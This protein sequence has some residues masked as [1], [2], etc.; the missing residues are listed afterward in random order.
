MSEALEILISV[1]CERWRGA[2]ENV[3]D[4]CRRAVL[5]AYTADPPD[6]DAAEVSLM[7][8]DDT[9]VQKLNRD[10][11]GK[12]QP[13][14]VLSFTGDHSLPEDPGAAKMLGDVVVAY[15][16][17]VS[18]AERDGKSVADHLTHLIVHGMLH[19]LG[20]EHR[21]D[22]EAEKMESLE[23]KVLAGLGIADP[24]REGA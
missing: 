2:V 12:D 7:L 18:E 15:D 4:L 5:A 9:F 10:Y 17:V 13:T 8:A 24:Y 20:Y 11:R 14:N 21:D 3:E 22:A 19:L 6:T 1:P 23:S 16:T